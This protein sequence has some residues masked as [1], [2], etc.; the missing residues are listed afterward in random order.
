MRLEQNR[1]KSPVSGRVGGAL[2]AMSVFPL[3]AR[4]ARR[5][6][7]RIEPA[8]RK[9]D[10]GRPHEAIPVVRKTLQV[11]VFVITNG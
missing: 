6:K 9:V 5:H 2:A 8:V 4:Q 11:R 10:N 7:Q 1:H 3:V